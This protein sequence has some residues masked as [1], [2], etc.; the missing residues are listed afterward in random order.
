MFDKW[1]W[2]QITD[3]SRFLNS[4]DDL[5][6]FKIQIM[7]NLKL[8]GLLTN[9]IYKTGSKDSMVDQSYQIGNDFDLFNRL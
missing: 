9:K 4:I 2:G 7:T 3:D 1:A 8:W 5:Y 6:I